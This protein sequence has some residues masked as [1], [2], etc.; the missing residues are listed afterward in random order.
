MTAG[1]PVSPLLH[2]LLFET[3]GSIVAGAVILWAVAAA[4]AMIGLRIR[5]TQGAPMMFLATI[6]GWMLVMIL[7]ASVGERDLGAMAAAGGIGG[8]AQAAVIAIRTRDGR[9]AR[10]GTEAAIGGAAFVVVFVAAVAGAVKI[11]ALQ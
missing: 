5:R 1:L 8:L 7:L 11:G 3:T 10:T 4:F 2:A 6:G 9:G